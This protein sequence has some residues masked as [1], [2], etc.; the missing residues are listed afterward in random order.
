[1]LSPFQSCRG[2]DAAGC[3]GADT[4]VRLYEKD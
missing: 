1:M 3:P 4:E 2:D